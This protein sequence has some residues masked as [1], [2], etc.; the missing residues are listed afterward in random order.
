LKNERIKIALKS[1]EE[2]ITQTKMTLDKAN[3]EFEKLKAE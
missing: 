3:K 1:K 2:Q